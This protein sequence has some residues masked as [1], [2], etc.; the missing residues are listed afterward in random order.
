[1]KNFVFV[2]IFLILSFIGQAQI[3]DDFVFIE[4]GKF[5]MG[6]EEQFDE[7]PIH[8]V[9][10]DDFYILNHEVTN[11][12]YVK[13]LNEKGN[14]SA[15]NTVW[16]DLKAKWQNITCHIYEKNGAFFVEE[17]YDDFPVVFVSWW[18]AQAYCEWL[19][20]RLPTEAE[21]EFVAKKAFGN[22]PVSIDTLHKYA[23]FKENA[24]IYSKICS[25]SPRMGIYD[26]FGNVSEWCFDWY[27][28][29][30]YSNTGRKN[31]QGPNIGDQKVK[32]GGSWSN[33]GM[34]IS[35]TNRKAT[36]A[37]NHSVV[38]GFRVVIKP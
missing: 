27:R 26:L 23:V 6:S 36:N 10:I 1:M 15:G 7:K 9:V 35:Q 13:F 2:S 4:G 8:K 20:G 5:K 34:A 24:K 16:I 33:S 25:K 37:N 30:Y 28:K 19:G 12:E 21:W 3:S 11:S 31:P 32:R 22:V 14:Q 18:G 29:D 17:G 38:L